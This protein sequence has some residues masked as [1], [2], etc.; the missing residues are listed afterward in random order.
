[1]DNPAAPVIETCAVY[2]LH[3]IV[4]SL[5]ICFLTHYNIKTTKEFSNIIMYLSE[6]MEI[7]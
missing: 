1:L 6:V 4:C 2:K 3:K 7:K 5:R